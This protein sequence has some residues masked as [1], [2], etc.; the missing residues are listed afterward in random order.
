MPETEVIACPACRH[1]VR[2]PADWLGQTVQ[3][4]ECKATFTAPT[5][6]GDR[7][8]EP[9]LLTSPAAT[10]A[11][12]SQAAYTSLR[13]PA[14]GLMLLGA[15]SFFVSIRTILEIAHNPDAYEQRKKEEAAEM[16]KNFGQDEKEQGEKHFAA[17]WPTLLGFAI[18][19]VICGG[20]TFAGGLGIAQRRWYRLARLGSALAIANV[21][22]CCCVPGAFVGLYTLS[23]LRTDEVRAQFR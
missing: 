19:G 10:G 2:V 22:G 21:A 20:F 17:N 4:P 6:D 3:C 14:C 16:A 13:L 9:V 1:L 15:V 23:L 5:R 18:W 7:L 8:G 11:T 12:P